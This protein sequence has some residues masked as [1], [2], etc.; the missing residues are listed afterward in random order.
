VTF[1]KKFQKKGEKDYYSTY[2]NIPKRKFTKREWDRFTQEQ[3]NA[4][5][6]EWASSPDV[7]RWIADNAHRVH[8]D[9]D[10]AT[11]KDDSPTSSSGSS[12]ELEQINKGLGLL[13]WR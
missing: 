7:A 6:A 10:S 9:R 13:Q 8:V 11:D 5:L 3:T 1:K 12:E 4:A 2:H